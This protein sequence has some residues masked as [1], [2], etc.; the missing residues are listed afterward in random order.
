MTNRRHLGRWRSP[1]A[2]QRFRVVEDDLWHDYFSARPAA[3]DI[4]TREYWVVKK[5]RNV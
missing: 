4:E 5:S 1:A 3:L 2:E